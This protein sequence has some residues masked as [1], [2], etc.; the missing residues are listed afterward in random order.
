[1]RAGHQTFEPMTRNTLD[2]NSVPLLHELS[3]LPVVV[4]PSHG[5]GKASLVPAVSRA[6]V[7]AGADGLMIEV[8]HD[9]ANAW[10]DGDQSLTCE[11]FSR[12][13]PELVRIREVLAT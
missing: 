7:A 3:H 9:P 10:S 6:A 4:D 11:A 12:L 8:H 1:V 5:T 2:I 13:S